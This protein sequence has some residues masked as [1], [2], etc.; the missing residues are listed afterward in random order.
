[1]AA[2]LN[3]RFLD[4]ALNNTL[5]ATYSHQYDPRSQEGGYFPGVDIVVG[6]GSE[7]AIYTVIGSETYTY[8]NLR[9]VHTAL[10]T[11]ELTYSAGIHNLLL[12]AQF[13]YNHTTNGY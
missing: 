10:V 13:E 3:S 11:D 7:R 6:E 8:G 5:R 12:G 9:D 4:G 1:M 2:E